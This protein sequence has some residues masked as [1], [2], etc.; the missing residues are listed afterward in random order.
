MENGI[1]QGRARSISDETRE[2]AR[3]AIEE[4]SDGKSYD[5]PAESLKV[6]MGR[7]IKAS[8]ITK[9]KASR[10]APKAE[11]KP[12]P[13]V[14][15]K[16]EAK[17]EPKAE[18]KPTPKAEKKSGQ[19]GS[20]VTFPR[21][22]DVGAGKAAEARKKSFEGNSPIGDAVDA[23]KRGTSGLR[24][25]L[26]SGSD[27]LRASKPKLRATSPSIGEYENSD[28]YDYAKGGSVGKARSISSRADGCAVKGK[29][30]AKYI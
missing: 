10:P 9:K 15:P 27:E 22:S 14:E 26:S 11:A 3:K 4:R 17:A 29:T 5:T 7:S 19:F 16:T 18:A 21:S 13:K 12:T 30:R 8:P 28:E 20:A 24:K 2:K 25:A 1:R 23:V 6:D